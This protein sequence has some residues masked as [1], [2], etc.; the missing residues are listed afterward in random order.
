MSPLCNAGIGGSCSSKRIRVIRAIRGT[1]QVFGFRHSQKDYSNIHGIRVL[2]LVLFGKEQ[3][4]DWLLTLHDIVFQVFSGCR[5]IRNEFLRETLMRA[6][7]MLVE[8]FRALNNAQEMF[9]GLSGV[10]IHDYAWRAFREDLANALVHRN[11]ALLG[12]VHIKWHDDHIEISNPGA[13][14]G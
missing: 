5:V 11:Y 7:E 13:L 4:L 1:T 10:S 8:R 2:G 12:V 6:M 9:L 14:S 3:A